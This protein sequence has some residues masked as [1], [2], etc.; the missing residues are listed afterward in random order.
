MAAAAPSQERQLTWAILARAVLH[1][2]NGVGAAPGDLDSV[3]QLADQLTGRRPDPMSRTT[4]GELAAEDLERAAKVGARLLTRDDSHWAALGFDDLTVADAAPVA[5]WVRGHGVPATARRVGV[6]GARA[7]TE[8][9]E[10]ITAEIARVLA[11]RDWHIVSGG[12]YG[13]DAL[14]HRAALAHA[15]G[16][17]VVLANGVDRA[18]PYPHRELFDR[19][20]ESGAIVSEYPP[21]SGPTRDRFLRRNRLV[22]ALSHAVVVPEAG[23]WSGTLNTAGWAHRLHRPVFAVPGP[24]DAAAS[25]GCHRLI[26]DRRAEP[27]TTTAALLAAIN[28]LSR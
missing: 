17:T 18:Y 25:A 13:V 16:T 3:E 9:G 22:A 6:V 24:A 4:V 26:Q 21:G 2:V 11:E 14:A 15:A 5:V 7:I 12:A 10:R 20:A 23:R 27:V 19:I 28:S 1:S 8:R